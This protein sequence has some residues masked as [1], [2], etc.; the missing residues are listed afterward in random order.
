MPIAIRI[1]ITEIA[2][3]FLLGVTVMA[4]SSVFSMVGG[5]LLGSSFFSS[6]TGVEVDSSTMHLLSLH[7]PESQP[8]S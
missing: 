4:G 7:L 2:R 6:L 5:S 8:Q 3:A 1:M